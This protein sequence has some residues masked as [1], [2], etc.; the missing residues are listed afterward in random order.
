MAS[1][2]FGWLYGFNTVADFARLVFWYA[3]LGF[4]ACGAGWCVGHCTLSVAQRAFPRSAGGE[5]R[6]RR[7][8]ARGLAQIDVYLR[9]QHPTS[10]HHA[11]PSPSEVPK[12][13]DED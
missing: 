3:W 4:I 12:S 10:P 11:P 8:V 13:A 2:S 6:V 1:P 7:D 5:R 9:E